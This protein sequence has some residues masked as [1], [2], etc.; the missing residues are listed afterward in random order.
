[1][2]GSQT[3]NTVEHRVRDARRPARHEPLG[4][5]GYGEEQVTKLKSAGAF[6]LPPKKAA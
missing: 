3:V 2:G 1:M 5:S 4:G 6:S